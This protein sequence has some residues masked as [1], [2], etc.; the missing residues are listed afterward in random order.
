MGILAIESDKDM[1]YFDPVLAS[2]AKLRAASWINQ[3]TGEIRRDEAGEI[4][5]APPVVA[6]QMADLERNWALYFREKFLEI[7]H[8][9]LARGEGTAPAPGC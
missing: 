4:A 5:E 9:A 8:D 1:D 7:D 6:T 3:A 2:E